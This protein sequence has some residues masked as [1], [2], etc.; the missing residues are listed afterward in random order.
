MKKSAKTIFK[1]YL[2]KNDLLYSKQRG[3][4]LD[5]FLKTEHHPTI[6]DLHELVRKENPKIG[7]ATVYRT[8]EI[9]YNAGLARKV[10]FGDGIKHYEHKYKHQDH[11]HLVCLNCG[12]VTEV[13]SNKL[14]EVQGKLAQ[15]YDFTITRVAIKLFGIC[16]TCK[17]KDKHS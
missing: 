15:K 4:I 14:E 7:L 10:G 9:I 2:K 8:M 13:T 12:K 11:H 6:N 1:E 16:K 5:I 3:Q 17:N